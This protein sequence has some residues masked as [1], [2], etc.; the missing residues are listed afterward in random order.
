MP[1]LILVIPISMEFVPENPVRTR[2]LPRN[3]CKIA[4]AIIDAGASPE[5]IDKTLGL[6]ASGS[7]PRECGVQTELLELLAV[8]NGADATHG[9][10]GAIDEGEWSAAENVASPR[11]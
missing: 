9:L 8:R 10:N 3:V 5:A 1:D 11:R 6:A 2:K 4:Q 7:V